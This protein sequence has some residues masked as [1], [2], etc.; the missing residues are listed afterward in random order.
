VSHFNSILE[1]IIQKL[2]LS[3]SPQ[4]AITTLKA[5]EST[6]ANSFIVLLPNKK[7]FNTQ[8]FQI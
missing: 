1:N 4:L 8:V 6:F 7:V 2:G 3:I 5:M